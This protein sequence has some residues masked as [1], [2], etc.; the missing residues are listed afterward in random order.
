MQPP[1]AG[2]VACSKH[3]PLN[4]PAKWTACHVPYID[5]ITPAMPTD[6]ETVW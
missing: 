3:A 4:H 6:I 1:S 2:A 5:D